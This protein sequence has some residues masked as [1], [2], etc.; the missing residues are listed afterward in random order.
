MNRENKKVIIVEGK[1]DQHRVKKLLPDIPVLTTNGSAVSLE[2]LN[3]VQELA[4]TSEIIL[5]LDPDYNGEVI[6]KKIVSVVP[7]ASHVFVNKKDA[8]SKSKKKLGVEHVSLSI[9]SRA[10]E[11]IKQS[12]YNKNITIQDIYDLGLAGCLN[13]KILRQKLCDKLGIGYVNA[14]QLVERLNLFN[15]TLDNIK[16]ML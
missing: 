9:L 11:N 8:I 4:K 5:L 6:R 15:Y 7:N 1:N 14:K 3:L 16:E 12:N 2:F 13:S 10:L